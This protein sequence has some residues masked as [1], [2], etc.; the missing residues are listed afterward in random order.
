MHRKGGLRA[1]PLLD[2]F[3]FPDPDGLLDELFPSLDPDGLLDELFPSL[4]PDGLPDEDEV[5]FDEL[6]CVGP[7][8]MLIGTVIGP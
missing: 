7:S 4:D 3:P 1:H 8:G 5:A 6:L 2:Y